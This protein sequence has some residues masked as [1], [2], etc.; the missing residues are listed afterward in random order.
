MFP[1]DQSPRLAGT[2]TPLK[3]SGISLAV[4]FPFD[5]SPRLAGTEEQTLE[6]QIPQTA[7]SIRSKSPTSR[8][9]LNGT[10]RIT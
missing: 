1:F 5:Q 3:L 6:A 2:K 8:D 9:R 7:V 4:G 10:S